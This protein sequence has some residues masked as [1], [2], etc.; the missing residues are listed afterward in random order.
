MK[1]WAKLWTIQSSVPKVPKSKLWELWVL[2]D[3]AV[4]SLEAQVYINPKVSKFPKFQFLE[5]ASF[6]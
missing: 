5:M 6:F 4:D 1:L 2:C 3:F